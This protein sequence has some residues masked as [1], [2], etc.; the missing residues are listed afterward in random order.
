MEIGDSIY[1]CE[2]SIRTSKNIVS[3]I[4]NLTQSTFRY[5]DWKMYKVNR[6]RRIF[7]PLVG[8]NN[9]KN[10]FYLGSSAYSLRLVYARMTIFSI[11]SIRGSYVG[12]R[13][14]GFEFV[15]LYLAVLICA[16]FLFVV[17]LSYFFY[18][19]KRSTTQLANERCEMKMKIVRGDEM[20]IPDETLFF[21]YV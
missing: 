4:Q 20:T 17:L 1:I 5:I 9:S 15:S 21:Q 12:K 16:I 3:F 18:S 13:R 10:T 6:V 8:T 7:I 2:E 19:L 14:L 11:R